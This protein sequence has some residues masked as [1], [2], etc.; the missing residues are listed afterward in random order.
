MAEKTRIRG[1]DSDHKDSGNG[2]C[3]KCNSDWMVKCGLT[4]NA[5]NEKQNY[6]CRS[7]THKTTAPLKKPAVESVPMRTK[8]P[9]KKRYLITAAQ[10]ATPIHKAF[11]QAFLRC[12]DYYGAEKVVIP[13]RYKNPT[14]QWT[15]DNKDHEWW[16]D[17]VVP[18]LCDGWIQL[19]ER[20]VIVGDVKVQWA[21]RKPLVGLDALTK[22]MSGIIGHGSRGLR[23]IATPQYKHP[24]LMFTTGACTVAN[25]TDSK[26]G[27]LGE[28]NHCLGALIVE[29]DAA[30]GNAFYVRQLDAT[31]DGSFIDL[32]MEFTPDGV[33]PAKPALSATIADLHFRWALPEVL[34]AT[35]TAPDSL[36]KLTDPR[37]FIWHDVLDF[38]SRNHH[39]DEDWITRYGKWKFGIECVKTEMDEVIQFLNKHT[40]KGKQSIIVS[41]NHDRAS[42]KWLKKADPKYDPVNAKFYH[43]CCLR[44]MEAIDK[45]IGGITYADAF[46]SYAKTLANDNVYYLDEGE[47]K[48]LM[49]VEHGFHGDRGPGG[50]RGSTANLS[51]M[52]IKVTKGHDHT[53]AILDACYSVGKATGM[54]EYEKG[55]P[56]AHTNSHVLQYANGKRT[57]ITIINGRFCL[58]RPR[59]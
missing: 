59:K 1:P 3:P 41:S 24:K 43:E 34:E 33:R 7:C 47:S 38:H 15:Q 27:A 18:Y 10:N 42:T 53:A 31:R 44:V 51:K 19:N 58:K 45:S 49:R 21:S 9:Q 12:A 39:H 32:D 6:K 57:I 22:D 36:V 46:V 2:Y 23:S 56:S 20:L 30:H 54:L 13:G 37:Y 5:G 8:L 52:G 17:A 11:W 50:S 35:L 26:A 4:T 48:A 25:Y 29:I 16:D 28:F 14:S 55:A 40:P